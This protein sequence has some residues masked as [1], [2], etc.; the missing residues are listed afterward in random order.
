MTEKKKRAWEPKKFGSSWDRWYYKHW[1]SEFLSWQNW[2]GRKR[3]VIDLFW[4]S[5]QSFI[6]TNLTPQ[7]KRQTVNSIQLQF[8]HCE[9]PYFLMKHY[10][11]RQLVLSVCLYG[12]LSHSSWVSPLSV[13]CAEKIDLNWLKNPPN[14]LAKHTQE[15][16]VPECHALLVVS[17]LMN[18]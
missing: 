10:D 3:E 2:G 11:S 9:T 12:C 14:K 6:C 18:N 5:T 15:V 8:F 7:D 4:I 16:F 1:V 13:W 17:R